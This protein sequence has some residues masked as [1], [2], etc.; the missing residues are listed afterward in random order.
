MAAIEWD[1][2]YSVGVVV[3]DGQHKE[4]IRLINALENDQAV[5]PVLDRLAVYVREHFYAEERLMEIAG[6]PGLADHRIEHQNFKEWLAGARSDFE[7]GALSPSDVAGGTRKYL[8]NWLLNHIQVV[9]KAYMGH[10]EQAN[11]NRHEPR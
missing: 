4:L 2:S 8:T 5:G 3:L 9:D 7:R 11:G 1:N 6:Y 10:V